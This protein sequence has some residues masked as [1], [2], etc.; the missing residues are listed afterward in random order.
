MCKCQLRIS[1]TH[2]VDFTTHVV[3]FPTHDGGLY[4]ACGGLS[5]ACPFVIPYRITIYEGT[6][7]RII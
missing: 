5:Y 7:L 3:D 1:I 6:I 4:Y 2:V